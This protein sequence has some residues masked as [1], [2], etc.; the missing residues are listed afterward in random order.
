MFWWM[1]V[2]IFV[3]NG[4]QSARRCV[5]TVLEK[6]KSFFRRP[7][8]KAEAKPPEPGAEAGAKKAPSAGEKKTGE[9]SK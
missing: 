5:M 4:K 6:I 9:A 8:A 7:R 2:P 3:W 1:L